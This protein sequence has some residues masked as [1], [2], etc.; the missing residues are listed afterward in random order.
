MLHI[1]D[2]EEVIRDSL[3]WLA[4]SRGIT[5]IPHESGK[6]FLAMLDNMTRT[7]MQGHALLLDVR[8]PDLSGIALFDLLATRGL[9]QTFPVIFLT[10]HG[11]VPMAVDALKRGAFDFF[12]K[13]FNDNKL[14]DR[15]QEALI[16][17]E[18]AI[19]SAAIHTRLAALSSREREV[20][21]LILEG[22]MNKVIADKLGI[23]MR[24]VEVHRAH[25]FDKMN[26]KTA[27]ELARLLK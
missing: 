22:K 16:A 9:T 3:M 10:G 8:M 14:M 24:T 5:A 7:G 25:I 1:I 6:A 18:E 19:A 20:L 17:S 26:V 12:E 2:D 13:P 4:K 21:D 15:V 27:V 11:D 23:S